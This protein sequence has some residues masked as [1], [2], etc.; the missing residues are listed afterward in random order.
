MRTILFIGLTIISLAGYA[1]T[2]KNECIKDKKN[3][4]L[5]FKTNQ[6]IDKTQGEERLTEQSVERMIKIRLAEEKAKEICG[7]EEKTRAKDRNF[8]KA[9]LKNFFLGSL[10][11]KADYGW[12]DANGFTIKSV[13]TAPLEFKTDESLWGAKFGY[14]NKPILKDI[15]L[16]GGQDNIDRYRRYKNKPIR[17]ALIDTVKFNM[18][19]GYGRSATVSEEAGEAS[20][21][22]KEKS[23]YYVGISYELPL[24]RLGNKFVE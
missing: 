3:E 12:T 14:F 24:S 15:Y 8:T 9:P 5:G 21:T 23:N 1:S 20:F 16:A 6:K 11:F 13:N 10:K 4:I 19:V 22:T 2:E 18:H 17:W 7:E